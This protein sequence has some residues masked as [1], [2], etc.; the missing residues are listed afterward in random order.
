MPRGT[1]RFTADRHAQIRDL[2]ERDGHVRSR[3]LAEQLGV[4]IETIR[5]DLK[6]LEGRGVL[7][8]M[9][10]GAAS[11]ARE[12]LPS[13]GAR[14]GSQRD[15]KERIAQL[16]KKLIE[17][18]MMVFLSG[19]S[20]TLALAWAL[21]DGPHASFTSN[22][23]DIVSVLGTG[24]QADVT[25]IGGRFIANARTLN[26]F[27]TMELIGRRAFDIAFLSVSAIDAR[28]G[29]LGRHDRHVAMART[30]RG[31]A[32]KVVVLATAEK[33]ALRD[34]YTVLGLHEVETVVADKPPSAEVYAALEAKG[35]RVVF[36]AAR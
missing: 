23:I 8:C 11:V 33:F 34:S 36:P 29:F 27:E 9:H 5:R 19:S 20:T 26:G 24:T 22:M 28:R 18:G 30:L 12:A 16:A 10:G 13:I 17:P 4:S 7:R 21:R 32:R 35:V 14:I 3:A 1:V 31:C 15:A 2:L 25:L 6:A